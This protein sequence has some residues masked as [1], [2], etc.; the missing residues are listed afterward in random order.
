MKKLNRLRRFNQP[1]N[2]IIGGMLKMSINERKINVLTIAP[3]ATDSSNEK[4]LSRQEAKAAFKQKFLQ[5]PERQP[6]FLKLPEHLDVVVLTPPEVV[7]RDLAS[8]TA[9]PVRNVKLNPDGSWVRAER[10]ESTLP[11][12]TTRISGFNF[13]ER[14]DGVYAS[15]RGSANQRITNAT[16]KIIGITKKINADDSV[17]EIL[18]CEIRCPDAWGTQAAVLDVP[19]EDFKNLF[20]IVRKKFRDIF[21]LQSRS[22]VLE[23]YLAVAN[24]RDFGENA[25]T[26]QQKT[27][28]AS[29]GWS[30]I[31]GECRYRLGDGAFYAG[32]EIP[33]V[34]L[35]NQWNIFQNG[36]SFRE[37]GHGNEISEV[38]WLFAHAPYVLKLFKEAHAPISSLLFLKG[39][40]NLFK[41]ATASVLA[42][43]F[44][45]D[46]S[47]VAIRLSSTQASLQHQIAALRDNLILVDDFSNTTGSDNLRMTRNAEFLIRAIGDG[48]FG[49]K[50]NVADFSKLANDS[51]R[52]AVVLTG[53]EG[54]DLDTSSLYRIV[55]LPV[56]E[57]TFDGAVLAKFQRDPAILRDYFALFI[58]FI[59]NQPPSLVQDIAQ[60]FL[61]HRQDC[62]SRLNVPRFIDFTATMTVLA[63]LIS[64]FA[65]WCG[66]DEIFAS[67]YLRRATNALITIMVRHQVES[68]ESDYV[69]RFVVALNQSLG[70]NQGTRIAQSEDDYARDEDTFIGF[71][72]AA[73][74][75]LWLR[76]DD[77]FA[78]TKKFYA[79]FGQSWNV[80]ADT[81]KEN[82][83]RRGIFEGTLAPKG[84]VGNEYLKRAKRGSRKRMLVLHLEELARFE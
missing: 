38:L 15:N 13:I 75:T 17:S 33:T 78:L 60:R 58:Q 12:E 77:A 4:K 27:V 72:E 83:L 21:V 16:V 25:S 52:V 3:R 55:T 6:N 53:E 39:R 44:K 51:I 49:S 42:N 40:T 43:V 50:M 7:E 41:T 76:F 45:S 32:Y 80:K 24:Q 82:L 64:N 30:T 47:N 48:R 68:G 69:R 18:T 56:C 23:E 59:E 65:R 81:L 19:S 71:N 37:V 5:R 14:D 1:L 63:E 79:K 46:R 62:A 35:E 31:D 34:Q 20:S 74:N 29:I 67:E 11:N 26:L 8:A 28:A 10:N 36:F 57:D 73:S 9:I 70:S 22:D 54:L 84:S 61:A 2:Y 66:C